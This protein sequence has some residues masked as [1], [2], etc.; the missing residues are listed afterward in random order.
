MNTVPYPDLPRVHYI[1]L[2]PG[3]SAFSLTARHTQSSGELRPYKVTWTLWS[4]LNAA[5]LNGKDSPVIW[6]Q[7]PKGGAQSKVRI[8]W[9]ILEYYK[10]ILF[11]LIRLLLVMW[12]KICCAN[13]FPLHE[14]WI[15]YL[16]VWYFNWNWP[17]ALSFCS[18]TS[19]L[20]Q[21]FPL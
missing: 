17:L 15:E 4:S 21:C 5:K 6:P 12:C 13:M 18:R 9:Y 2:R 19:P 20:I 14:F 16:N 7:W 8:V 10:A 1:L 3:V 11:L